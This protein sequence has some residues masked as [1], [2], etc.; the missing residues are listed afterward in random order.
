MKRVS[1][2]V[3]LV[4][5]AAL[6]AAAQMKADRFRETLTTEAA[7]SEEDFRNL[8]S[9]TPV[10][11]LIEPK[12]RNEIAVVGVIRLASG[13]P[14]TLE[15]FRESLTQKK[16]K[17]MSS[18]GLFSNPPKIADVEAL[19]LEDRDYRELAKC[20]IR[21]CDLNLTAADIGRL[22]EALSSLDEIARREASS[23]FVKELLVGYVADYLKRGHNSLSPYANKRDEFDLYASLNSMIEESI[24]ICDVSPELAAYVRDFPK[25]KP[26][27]SESEI[28]WSQIEFGLNPTIVLTHTIAY[29]QQSGSSAQHIVVNKQFYGTRY[30]DASLSIALLLAVAEEDGINYYVV[31]T[32]RTTT[33]AIDGPF[34]AVTKRLVANEAVERTTAILEWSELKLI[35]PFAETSRSPGPVSGE[36]QGSRWSIIAAVAVVLAL[37]LWFLFG[38]KV[39]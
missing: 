15:L 32:D 30:F 36:P 26:A 35:A 27:G 20:K 18:G 12:H 5:A 17:S 1:F 28:R 21:D 38:R 22:K 24:L 11:K 3:I 7:F 25:S 10:V 33:D 8:R 13:G 6:T 14:F 16:N 4:F 19:E 23:K 29:S 9:G 2:G 37:I 39:R 34:G 31:F